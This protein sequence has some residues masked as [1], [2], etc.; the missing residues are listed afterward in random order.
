MIRGVEQY[1]SSDT[2]DALQEILEARLESEFVKVPP[3]SRPELPGD[4]RRWGK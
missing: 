1:L 3:M 4:S 2:V